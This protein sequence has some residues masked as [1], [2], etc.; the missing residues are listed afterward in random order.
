MASNNDLTKIIL[1]D[2]ATQLKLAPQS[3]AAGIIFEDGETLQQKYNSGRLMSGVDLSGIQAVSPTVEI[4]ENDDNIY[5]LKIRDINGVIITPNLKGEKGNDGKSVYDI[6]IESGFEGTEEEWLAT[7]EGDSA[8]EIAIKNG[9]SGNE[10][11][12][13]LSLKGKDGK[14][15]KSAYDLA[16]EN[17]FLGTEKE[18]LASMRG[19]QGDSAYDIAV[20][21]G[22]E[23]TPRE[24][25]DSLDGVDGASAYDIAVE[26]GFRGTPEEWLESL[27]NGTVTKE[28]IG[29]GNVDN[30]AD[31]KKVVAKAGALTNPRE[32]ALTGAFSAVAEFDGTKDIALDVQEV[33]ATKLIGLVPEACLPVEFIEN[34][35]VQADWNVEDPND[36]A[37][38]KNKPDIPALID[39]TPIQESIEENSKLIAELRLSIDA[40]AAS[41]EENKAE[42]V[43]LSEAVNENLE[44][45]IQAAGLLIEENKQAIASVGLLVEENKQAINAANENIFAQKESLDGILSRVETIEQN[46][47]N[48]LVMSNIAATGTIPLAVDN[49]TLESSGVKLNDLLISFTGE[50]GLIPVNVTIESKVHGESTVKIPES[51]VNGLTF[52]VYHN[53]SLLIEGLHYSYN[54]GDTVINLLGFTTYEGDL[55]TFTAFAGENGT[56][57]ITPSSLPIASAEE[58]G[59]VKSTE[60]IPNFVSVDAEGRMYIEK[61]TLNS[62]ITDESSD[63]ETILVAG[64]SI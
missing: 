11:D 49:V 64:T 63:E 2:D 47:S 21:Y 4:S 3:L 16:L 13:L 12:W 58:R 36:K 34:S 26:H 45:A 25:I 29:L 43:S 19:K 27:H 57:E 24:W 39:L 30:T 52:N 54:Q 20:E 1:K 40:N 10:L 62:I 56:L 7:L 50:A 6:A 23:G 46:A 38:I 55:F 32:I 59:A 15:G 42:I 5:R 28:S 61:I 35:K 33:D 53:G 18:W 51:M 41:I 60:D 37:F 22:F 9:F 17:G 8:Y 31:I 44:S 14:E 48:H